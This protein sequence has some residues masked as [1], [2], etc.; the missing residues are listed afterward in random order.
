[1][2]AKGH[3]DD[4]RLWERDFQEF[5]EW[6]RRRH[7]GT[8]LFLYGQS[9]GS[10]TAILVLREADHSDQL[11]V[12]GIILHS[13]AVAMM[14]ASPVLRFGVGRLRDLNPKGLLF[15]VGLI[16]GEKPALTNDPK[17]DR[18][19]GLSEDRVRPGFSWAFFDETLKMG[20]RAQ[21]AI[22]SLNVPVIVLTG[23]KDPI[24]TAGVGQRA[25]SRF[26]RSV[27]SQHKEWQRFDDGY[28]DLIH[29]SNTPRAVECVG[30]WMERQLA[31]PE[32][33]LARGGA[34]RDGRS[35]GL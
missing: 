5:V 3:V 4:G 25:F 30:D 2:R 6:V 7:Q 20:A 27:P 21:A 32:A 33:S 28:H 24:G 12:S 1:Q 29:D 18:Y 35:Q 11:K 13:P 31:M 14:Y 34:H 10:L 26:L 8:P 15:N 22:A 17:F 16:S 23:E 19:W 9:M